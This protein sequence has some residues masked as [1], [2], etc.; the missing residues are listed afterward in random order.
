MGC[1]ESA[2]ALELQSSQQFLKTYQCCKRRSSANDH[3]HTH[4]PSLSL[5][6]Y[7]CMSVYI[8]TCM[9]MHR[10]RPKVLLKQPFIKGDLD[11]VPGWTASMATA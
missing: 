2:V 11:Q 6:I 8:Y 9:F 1:A 5:S 3:A 7:T 4:R 10:G